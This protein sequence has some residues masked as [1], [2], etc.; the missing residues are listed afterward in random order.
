MHLCIYV[1]VSVCHNMVVEAKRQLAN[2]FIYFYHVGRRHHKSLGLAAGVYTI[3]L[4][5][6]LIY[7]T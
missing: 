1:W 2:L 7:F 4:A 6:K 5:L 3:S